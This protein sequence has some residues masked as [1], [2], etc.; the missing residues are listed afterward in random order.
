MSQSIDFKIGFLEK[1]GVPLLS[2]I[3][4]G[5]SDVS[6]DEGSAISPSGSEA[7]NMAELLG[8]SVSL[9][10]ELVGMLDVGET[11]EDAE[12]ARVALAAV[13]AKVI[14]NYK[15]FSGKMPDDAAV[16]RLLSAMET[17]LM[18][19]DHFAPDSHHIARLAHVDPEAGN[20]VDELQISAQYMNIMAPVVAVVADY[21][22]GRNEKKLVLEIA[23]RLLTASKDIAKKAVA[24][25][26]DAIRLKRLEINIMKA[27]AHLFTDCYRQ[28]TARIKSM[29]DDERARLSEQSGGAQL[30]MDNLWGSFSTRFAILGLLA[31]LPDAVV[32]TGDSAGTSAFVS[33]AP[34]SQ[35][36]PVEIPSSQQAM[37]ETPVPAAS[38]PP[39]EDA[40]A[41]PPVQEQDQDGEGEGPMSFFVKKPQ[42]ANTEDE[43][44]GGAMV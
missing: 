31:G 30:S 9:G 5:Q 20:A 38:P 12:S 21:T 15:S 33:E 24:G 32:A 8:Q 44:S 36:P 17:A 43:S 19:S 42:S 40:Q 4:A 10:A 18:F 11:G 41:S 2:A 34:V 26:D 7:K 27:A 25:D 3:I 39:V 22:F 37:H 1:I 13:A 16:K 23:E 28:E 6:A 35:T 29:S 14:S